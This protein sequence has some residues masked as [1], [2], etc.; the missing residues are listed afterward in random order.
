[1]EYLNVILAPSFEELHRLA[2]AEPVRNFAAKMRSPCK[3]I[4][5]KDVSVTTNLITR[6]KLLTALVCSL[7]VEATPPETVQQP[8]LVIM[9]NTMQ[10]YKQIAEKYCANAEVIEVFH[11]FTR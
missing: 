2:S 6:L 7:H 9:E 11:S 10:L 1:M 5:F 4:I 3:E 8:V